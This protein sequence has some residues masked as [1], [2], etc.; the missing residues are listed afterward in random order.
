MNI[1]REE[2]LY[3]ALYIFFGY[4]FTLIFCWNK[5]WKRYILCT[6]LRWG[7]IWEVVWRQRFL[8]NLKRKGELISKKGWYI[9]SAKISRLYNSSIAGK[10]LFWGCYVVLIFQRAEFGTNYGRKFNGALLYGSEG[11]TN[12]LCEHCDCFGSTSRDR[13]FAFRAASSLESTTR[14]QRAFLIFSA[15]SNS[16]ILCWKISLLGAFPCLPYAFP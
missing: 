3:K 14:E 10:H 16:S 5:S 13:K 9:E 12:G 7:D 8:P 6:S 1:Y 15:C 4:S 2:W 11:A